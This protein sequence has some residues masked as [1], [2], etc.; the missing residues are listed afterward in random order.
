MSESTAEN[1]INF[2]LKKFQE[3]GAEKLIINFHGGEPL[4]DF[5]LI[6]Y[7]TSKFKERF[8]N[9]SKLLLFGLTTNGLLLNDD[10]I[11]FLSENMHW[12]LSVSLDGDILVN[13]QNRLL[14]NRSGSYN[15]VIPN[16]LKLLNARPD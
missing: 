7:I 15:L 14:N 10:N 5:D 6:K 8:N 12:N 9:S 11:S 13:D 3:I 2:I 1:V 4:L 16:C